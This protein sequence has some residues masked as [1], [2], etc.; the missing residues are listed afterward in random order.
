MADQALPWGHGMITGLF[1]S[2]EGVEQAYRAAIDLGY[3]QS[4]VNLM[5][6]DGNAPALFLPRRRRFGVGGESAGDG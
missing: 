5:M 3:E 2:K 1:R 4:D 6:S